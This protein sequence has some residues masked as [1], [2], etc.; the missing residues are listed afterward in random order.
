MSIPMKDGDIVVINYPTRPDL[1]GRVGIM[2]DQ[3]PNYKTKAV[4]TG[5]YHVQMEPEFLERYSP[6]DHGAVANVLGRQP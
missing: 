6:Y 1:H 5:W 4:N 2:E 3:G